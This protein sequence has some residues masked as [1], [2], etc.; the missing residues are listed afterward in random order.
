M[1]NQSNSIVPFQ[2][3]EI[4]LSESVE[5][6][7]KPYFTRKAIGE[8]LGYADPQ[9]HVDKIIER[10]PHIRE[11]SKPVN[12]SVMQNTGKNKTY[13]RKI[14]TE[15]YDPIGFQLIVMESRQ[16]K[17]IKYK[18]AVAHLVQAYMSGKLGHATKTNSNPLDDETRKKNAEARDRNSKTR[19][20]KL[21]MDTA[22]EFR[23]CLAPE[24]VQT[25][26]CEAT[27]IMTGQMLIALPAIEGPLYSAEDIS[28]ELLKI[29]FEI[30]ANMV[31]RIA[32]KLNIK[33]DEP[34]DGEPRVT[35]YGK[36]TMS[37]SKYSVR[38]VNYFQYNDKGKQAIIKYV[39]ANYS[40]TAK[41]IEAETQTQLFGA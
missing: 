30:S 17:A 37:K 34:K 29:G 40:E 31:G 16:P 5:I 20:A 22:K 6:N 25:M 39:L 10:N 32:N 14:E 8:W 19:M 35:P 4:Q 28:K 18:V 23:S 3:Q 27:N 38:Q 26:I 41:E 15:V 2:Y 21:L 24:T 9:N 7:G 12:L 33:G 1:S 36:W 13:E 11:F